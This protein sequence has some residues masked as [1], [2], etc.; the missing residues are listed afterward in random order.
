MKNYLFPKIYMG[1]TAEELMMLCKE[2]GIDG[3]T[4]LIR[5]GYWMQADNMKETLPAFVRLAEQYGLE[6][7]YAETPF[8]MERLPE[9]GDELAVMADCGIRQFRVDFFNKNTVPA[10]ELAERLARMTETAA[11]AAARHGLRAVVQLHGGAYPHSATAAWPAVKNLDPRYIGIKLDPGNNLQQEGYE[12]FS[13]QI[14]LL[15]EYIA[16]IGEK[17]GAAA[18]LHPSEKGTKGWSVRWV[19]AQQGMINYD[20][21]FALLKKQNLDIPGILM[22][23]YEEGS[24]QEE[25][26]YFLRC[27]REAGLS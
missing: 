11:K 10:R 23:F 25:I 12:D 15:G 14:S 7:V 6:V 9:L 20:N 13:Y 18:C 4:A 19:P 16:A 1:R 21:I 5:D 26:A 2:L 22:P 3:P 8:R 24:L 27:Q 17:D